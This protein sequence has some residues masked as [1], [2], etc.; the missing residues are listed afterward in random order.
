VYLLN[1]DGD[2]HGVDETGQQWSREDAVQEPEAE[3]AH[4]KQEHARLFIRTHRPVSGRG[5]RLT[6]KKTE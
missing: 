3:H 2:G 4:R 6:E 1:D 5:Q